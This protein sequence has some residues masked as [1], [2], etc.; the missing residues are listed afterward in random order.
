MGA[1]TQEWNI[2]LD[3]VIEAML[4]RATDRNKIMKDLR[5]WESKL[6]NYADKTK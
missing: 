5:N 4:K 6:G 3:S 2:G 1:V